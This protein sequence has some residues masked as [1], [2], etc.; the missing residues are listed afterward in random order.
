LFPFPSGNSSAGTTRKELQERLGPGDTFVEFEN[1]LNNA[2]NR[3]REALG[4]T[5]GSPRFIE[6]VPRPGYRF[7]PEV[8]EAS[9]PS[10][11]AASRKWMFAFGSILLAGLV[12]CG[13]YRLARGR[14]P[15]IHS[16]AVL[17]FRNLSTDV[18]DEY[19]TEGMTDAGGAVRFATKQEIQTGHYPGVSALDLVYIRAQ[20]G[21]RRKFLTSGGI[22]HAT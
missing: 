1:G 9:R 7:V 2:I 21:T 11:L 5:S 17:P 16:L 20:L 12:V 10:R 13:V 22:S 6:T 15:A 4:D 8:A 14:E 3:L 18:P 19:F